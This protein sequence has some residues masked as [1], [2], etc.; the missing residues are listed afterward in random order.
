TA[1]GGG[2]TVGSEDELF[3]KVPDID[4]YDQLRTSTDTHVAIAIRGIGEIAPADFNNLPA[5]PSR[6]D[7]DSATDEYGIR[8]V[9]VTLTAT[10]RDN[11][12]WTAMDAAMTQVMNV[13][14]N[15]Q[16]I[17]LIQA[18]ASGGP[19]HAGLRTT[20]HETGTLWIGTDS[21]KS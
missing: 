8:R 2:N 17:Q 16:P 1:S 13:F 10:Q 9:S 12:L 20:H 14:A 18:N 11:D 21:T 3:R 6:V 7:L 15:G 5:H 4:F 19:T